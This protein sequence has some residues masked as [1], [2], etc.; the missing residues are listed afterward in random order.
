V[1]LS[2]DR[3]VIFSTHII[4]DISSSCNALAVLDR[5]E[6]KY[7]GTPE[8]MVNQAR[9]VVWQVALGETEFEELRNQLWVVHHIRENGQIKVRFLAEKPTVAS[10]K[11]VVPTLE[12]AYL[13]LLGQGAVSA[14]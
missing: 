10:A 2:R 3:I 4:E 8:E 13:W 1:E 12:D 11:T 5:G 6:L 14:K 7:L 9:G